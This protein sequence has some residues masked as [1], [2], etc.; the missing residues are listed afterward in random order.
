MEKLKLDNI[1]TDEFGKMDCTLTEAMAKVEEEN[2]EIVNEWLAG[3]IELLFSEVLDGI[4][5]KRSFLVRL[6]RELDV[7]TVARYMADWTAKQENRKHKYLKG[8]K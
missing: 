1:M 6:C 8:D 4:Q 2:E 7:E 5:A 3:N